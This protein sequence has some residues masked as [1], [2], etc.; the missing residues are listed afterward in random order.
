MTFLALFGIAL[1]FAPIPAA[2]I[3]HRRD[4]RRQDAADDIERIVGGFHAWAEHTPTQPLRAVA[5]PERQTPTDL[6][7]A[8]EPV[9][10]TDPD[11]AANELRAIVYA[12]RKYEELV[13]A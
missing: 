7:P 4:W 12:N 5:W 3:G 2:F 9:P 10:W 11:W 13:A 1:L 8:Y 6:A